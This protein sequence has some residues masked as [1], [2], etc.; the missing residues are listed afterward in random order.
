MD[1]AGPGR[2][3]RLV[4]AV[5]DVAP[6]QQERA[7]RGE[8]APNNHGSWFAAQTAALALFV[9]D[10]ATAR[11]IVAAV[12]AR[13]GWQI[14]PAGDQPIELERTRSYHY[15]GFNVEALSRLAEMG[16][17]VGVDL[18]RYQAPEGGSLRRAIDHLA[19]YAASPKDW[20]GQQLDAVD[21][22]GL[23]ISFRRAQHAWGDATYAPVL[24]QLPADVVRTDRSALLYP[25]AAR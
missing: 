7:G 18:W 10:T 5:P 24:R 8:G 1:G 11:T 14:T 19:R 21:L 3:A 17:L 20:P 12:P 25:D 13:I 2:P 15:S 4:H 23:L 6:H 22:D 16:R 9:G